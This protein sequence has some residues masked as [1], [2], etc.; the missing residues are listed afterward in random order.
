[1]LQRSVVEFLCNCAIFLEALCKT[2]KYL[3]T[4]QRLEPDNIW[5]QIGRVTAD[6]GFTQQQSAGA[7]TA[8]AL[9]CRQAYVKRNKQIIAYKLKSS[10]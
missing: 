5:K 10:L 8:N 2:T 4:Q 6:F 3:L 7:T 1:M 9:W